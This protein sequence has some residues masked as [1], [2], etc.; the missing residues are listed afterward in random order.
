MAVD[1]DK[2]LQEVIA[3]HGKRTMAEAKQ[4]LVAMTNAKRYVRDVY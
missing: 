3:L 1:V 2:A 4:Y